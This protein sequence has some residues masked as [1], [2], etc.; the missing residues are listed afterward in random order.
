SPKYFKMRLSET[1]YRES[2][3]RIIKFKKTG[4]FLRIFLNPI[5]NPLTV[6]SRSIKNKIAVSTAVK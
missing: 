2:A 5:F 1:K 6:F 4:E 3:T